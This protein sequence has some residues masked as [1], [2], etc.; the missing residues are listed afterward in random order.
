MFFKSKNFSLSMLLILFFISSTL[1]F[2]HDDV[3]LI[4]VTPAIRDYAINTVKPV[5]DSY[6]RKDK[7]SLLLKVDDILINPEIGIHTNEIKP[8]NYIIYDKLEKL[9]LG[10]L[11]SFK[12]SPEQKKNL[13]SWHSKFMLSDPADVF[14]APSADEIIKT[15]AAFGCSHYARSFIAVVKALGLMDKPEDLRYV[16]SSKADDY[17]KALERNDSEMTINGHQFVIAKIDS[18]WIAINTSKS[19]W[20]AMPEGFSPNSIGPPKNF[21]IRF[22]SYPDV[23]F[24]FRKIGKN[25]DDD[26]NDN[27]LAALMNIYRSGD[28][29]GSSFKWERFEVFDSYRGLTEVSY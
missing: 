29:Q 8:S 27:S 5:L 21:P 24:L 2:S 28:S 1:A 10:F 15:K 18:K 9:K 11:I 17:N 12:L 4:D 20:A 14:F 7:L 22:P 23:T 26:C 13:K 16:I 25:Y 19:E 6:D 3:S